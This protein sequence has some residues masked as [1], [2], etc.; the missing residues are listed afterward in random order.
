MI[1]VNVIECLLCAKNW[2]MWFA[3]IILFMF[4]K[5]TRQSF[6]P[7]FTDEETRQL[8]NIQVPTDSK[9]QADIETTKPEFLNHSSVVLLSFLVISTKSNFFQTLSPLS[10][11]SK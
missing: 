10:F 9:Q 11:F 1:I 4:Q 7:D 3:F 8:H 5:K 6:N 2:T